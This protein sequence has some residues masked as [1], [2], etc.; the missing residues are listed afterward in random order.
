MYRNKGT[1]LV[2]VY[3]QDAVMWGEAQGHEVPPVVCESVGKGF[4]ADLTL[5]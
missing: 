1:N 5:V 2:A 3:V 4:R